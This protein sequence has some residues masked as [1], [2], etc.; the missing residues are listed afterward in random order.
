MTVEHLPAH[1]PPD[2]YQ[3][4]PSVIADLIRR[5][6]EEMREIWARHL[7]ELQGQNPPGQVPQ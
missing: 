1:Y 6:R 3:L 2:G 4:S 7:R 5:H